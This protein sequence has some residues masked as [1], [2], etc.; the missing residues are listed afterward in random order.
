MN[1]NDTHQHNTPARPGRPT[2][3]PKLR[4]QLLLLKSGESIQT[5]VVDAPRLAGSL[6]RT[7]KHTGTRFEV[8][9][10]QGGVTKI[11]RVPH[12]RT[13]PREELQQ[14]RARLVRLTR[15]FDVLIRLA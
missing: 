13:S 11:T 7:T 4:A 14:I 15:A 2:C 3:N 6:S 8:R 9:S 5:P 10:I 12:P 1:N